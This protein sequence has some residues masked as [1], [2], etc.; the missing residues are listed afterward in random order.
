M[1]TQTGAEEHKA[2]V[3]IVDDDED[4]LLIFQALLQKTGFNVITSRSA[5]EGLDTLASTSVDLIICD[6][7]M[8]QQNG[9]WFIS[10]VRQH[11]TSQRLPVIAFSASSDDL[12]ESLLAAGADAYCPKNRARNLLYQT[13]SLLEGTV[14]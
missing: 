1:E 5:R 10:Q 6:V 4:Q 14:H 9:R 2:V 13:R 7:L 3:L 8:P 12:E 11:K